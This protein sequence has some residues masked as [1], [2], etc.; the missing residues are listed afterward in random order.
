LVARSPKILAQLTVVIFLGRLTWWGLRRA[1]GRVGWTPT[2]D[3][4][5]GL[6]MFLMMFNYGI[7]MD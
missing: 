3:L 6:E 7:D 5:G 1:R 2:V 4:V